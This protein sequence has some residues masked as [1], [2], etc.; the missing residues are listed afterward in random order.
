VQAKSTKA[1]SRELRARSG[2]QTAAGGLQGGLWKAATRFLQ[3]PGSVHLACKL[4]PWSS[5]ARGSARRRRPLGAF[6]RALA[7]SWGRL[8]REREM[9]AA[10]KRVP[11]RH[12]AAGKQSTAP[13]PSQK[14]SP[15]GNKAT[16]AWV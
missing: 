16:G 9:F 6:S 3:G 14:K 8:R 11:C 7:A 2:E 12:P 1:W 4:Q 15:G 5:P 10:Y 13:V